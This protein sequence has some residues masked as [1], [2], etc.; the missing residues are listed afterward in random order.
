MLNAAAP[1][2]GKRVLEFGCGLGTYMHEMRRFVPAPQVFGFD[3]ELDRLIE[4]QR[5]GVDGMLGAVGESLPFADATFD[6]VFT[7]EVLEHV[8]DDRAA[9]R[10]IARVLRR[11]GRSVN[12]V[13]N[14]L[15]FFETH[16]IYWRGHY[17]FGN[18]PLVNWLPDGLR[19]K[20][21]PHV[22]AYTAHGIRSIFS[23]AGLRVVQHTQIYG[24]FDNWV[25][26]LGTAGKVLRGFWQRLEASPLRTFGLSHLIVLEKS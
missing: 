22:R 21:A 20:L 3:V 9:A 15:Y 11:G 26:R 23:G 7:N 17:Q 2:A 13:P 4:G 8:Q 5:R 19:N 25:A 1:L 16:G 10:E 6:I 24:G 18:K 14:R 12:F